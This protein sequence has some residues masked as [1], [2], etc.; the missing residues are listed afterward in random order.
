MGGVCLTFCHFSSF[1]FV[2]ETLAPTSKWHSDY[3]EAFVPGFATS[4][5]SALFCLGYFS[6]LPLL[7]G[8][9]PHVP[10]W[11]VGF[12]W[13]SWRIIGWHLSVFFA[14]FVAFVQFCLPDF[15]LR[16]FL[17]GLD[18]HRFHPDILAQMARR[19][20][21]ISLLQPK[22][23]IDKLARF[24]SQL[25]TNILWNWYFVNSLL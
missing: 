20:S 22:S 6:F 17:Q 9:D 13:V 23:S 8:F 21:K 3:W 7:Q 18:I 14:T 19:R 16:L 4:A 25:V 24:F 11:H 15:C 12:K 10:F 5:A 1:S 2:H